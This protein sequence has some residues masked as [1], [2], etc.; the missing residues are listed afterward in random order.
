[1]ALQKRCRT[2]VFKRGI[3]PKKIPTPLT[4]PA[5]MPT[6]VARTPANSNAAAYPL[7]I[8]CVRKRA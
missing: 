7:C 8:M 6:F 2:T 5:T 3:H 1:L 4:A